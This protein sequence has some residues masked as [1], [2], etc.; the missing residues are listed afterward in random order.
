VTFPVVFS[1]GGLQVAAHTVFETL[2]YFV[3]FR[4]YLAQRRRLGDVLDNHTR[5]SVIAGAIAGALVG[6]KL[7]HMLEDPVAT[8]AK[9]GDLLL[10]F[11]GKTVV[12]G[13]IGGLAGVELTKTWIGVRQS[14]GDLLALPLAIGI[15][16]GR[17]GCFLAGPSDGTSGVPSTLPWA[18]DFG[19]G[20][21]RHPTQLYEILALVTIAATLFI[22]RRRPHQTGDLFKVLMVG[23]MT[24]RLL[25][26]A[27]KPEPRIALGLSTLQWAALGVLVYYS[28][29]IRR[30]MRQA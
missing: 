28:T 23:Y 29:D 19:D 5:W 12:G 15:A 3:G 17:I 2:A 9:R 26:D 4:I 6:A 20:I 14:T 1:I 11:G 7:L 24:C 10:F 22:L 8:W 18:V 16:I 30:W 25:V 21:A 13:L 27:I